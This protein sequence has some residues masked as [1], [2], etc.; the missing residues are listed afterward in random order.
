MSFI[1]PTQAEGSASLIA[2]SLGISGRVVVVPAQGVL[3]SEQYTG[4]VNLGRSRLCSAPLHP[5][6]LCLPIFLPL[7]TCPR[8]RG[9]LGCGDQLLATLTVCSEEELI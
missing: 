7:P 8:E 9:G 6:P 3:M 5:R 1:D 2:G 4:A